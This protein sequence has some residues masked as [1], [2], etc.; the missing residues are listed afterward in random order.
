MVKK[1][2]NINTNGTKGI[3]EKKVTDH[4]Y[5]KYITIHECNKLTSKHFAARL[6]QGN[7]ATK[8]DI[9]YFVKK[10]YSDDKRKDLNKNVISSKTRQAEVKNNLDDLEKKLK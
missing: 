5:D 8:N 3:G 9:A 6:A 7:A 4:D 10:T 2:N 1:V